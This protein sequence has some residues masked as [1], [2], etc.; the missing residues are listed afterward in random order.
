MNFL[1]G[2][3]GVSGGA[4]RFSAEGLDI[5]LARYTFDAPAPRPGAAVLGIRPEHVGVG[6]AGERLPFS[7]KVEIEIVEPMG[8]DTLVWTKLGRPELHLPRRFGAH[9]SRSATRSPS[10]S[11][12][13]ASLFD[14][15]RGRL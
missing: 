5:P 10:A 13:P 1:D 12:R 9:A 2:E 11:I 14:A 7:T 6:D 8:S 3:V 4:P 15:C